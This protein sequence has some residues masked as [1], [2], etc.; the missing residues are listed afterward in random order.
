M[1]VSK[2]QR[3]EL[4]F[5]E[6]LGIIPG[7]DDESLNSLLDKKNK[8]LSD[9]SF[10]KTSYDGISFVRYVIAR[11]RMD[12]AF[13]KTKYEYKDISENDI[14]KYY[15]EHKI[16]FLRENKEYFPLEE[17]KLVIKKRLREKEYE[18]AINDLLH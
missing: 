9:K 11:F 15:E 14:S 12:F 16:E 18:K 17:M 5:A 2:R 8:E 6:S 10:G 4:L 3:A 7:A 13:E 1:V